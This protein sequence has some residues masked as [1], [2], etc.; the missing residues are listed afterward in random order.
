MV[1]NQTLEEFWK[2]PMSD[3]FV[4]LY[5]TTPSTY[6]RP[7]HWDLLLSPPA[8]WIPEFKVKDQSHTAPSSQRILIALATLVRP[9]LWG[10]GTQFEQLPLH[11]ALYLEFEGEL[12]EHRGS[13]QRVRSGHV[14]WLES[15]ASYLRFQLNEPNDSRIKTF[16][17]VADRAT[18]VAEDP[19]PSSPATRP[20]LWTISTLQ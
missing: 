2:K 12:S 1:G 8:L 20:R 13:V 5:H 17:L 19:W 6:S 9:E 16:E 14:T 3:K 4:V 10:I 11:R 7:S 15:T 18:N